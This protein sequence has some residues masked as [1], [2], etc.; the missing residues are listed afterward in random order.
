MIRALEIEKPEPVAIGAVLISLPSGLKSYAPTRRD[1]LCA[2]LTGHVRTKVG[3]REVC[4]GDGL[5]G[6]LALR[7]AEPC[8]QVSSRPRR[9]FFSRQGHINAIRHMRRS[10]FP[11]S[12]SM[13]VRTKPANLFCARACPFVKNFSPATVSNL[14]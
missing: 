2:H 4:I 13:P 1:H 11:L 10:G 14:D 9:R 8:G 6:D 12:A 3:I 5:R 7:D